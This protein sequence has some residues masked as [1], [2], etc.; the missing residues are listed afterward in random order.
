MDTEDLRK[1][2]D[3]ID[4]GDW[5]NVNPPTHEWSAALREAADE[6]EALKQWQTDMLAVLIRVSIG[7]T[8]EDSQ[9]LADLQSRAGCD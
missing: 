3:E 9:V 6:I 8:P 4:A 7:M 1:M 5:Y 2:A